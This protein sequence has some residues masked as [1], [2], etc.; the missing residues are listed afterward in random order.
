MFQLLNHF[1]ELPCFLKLS[2]NFLLNLKELP[3][4]PESE[5]YVFHFRLAK[6]HCWGASGLV[7]R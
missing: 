1:T 6:N 7:C 5:F 3:C 4:H 2:S